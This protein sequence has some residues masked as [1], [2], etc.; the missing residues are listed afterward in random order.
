MLVCNTI[1]T[2][3]WSSPAFNLFQQQVARRIHVISEEEEIDTNHLQS[4]TKISHL[5]CKE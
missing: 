4:W 1:L 3:N 2:E 5:V